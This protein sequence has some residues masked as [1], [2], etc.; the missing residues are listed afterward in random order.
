MYL[1]TVFSEINAH[2]EI[3]AL[4][5]QWFFKGGSTQN[6]WLLMGDFPKEGVNKTDG[7]WWMIFQR[8]EYMKPMGFDGW[9][10]KGGS[11]Q[12]RWLLMG[13]FP[14]EE[15]TKP[16]AFDGLWNLLLMLLKIKH[17]GRLFRQIRYVWYI[18]VLVFSFVKEVTLKRRWKLQPNK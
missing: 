7:V 4:Q 15:Y 1:Y 2:L 8:G 6:R 13:D 5:K 16:M 14:R 11:T 17:P 10:S 18:S 12:N 9:F 3:S